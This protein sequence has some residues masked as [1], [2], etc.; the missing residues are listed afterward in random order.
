MRIVHLIE[1]NKKGCLVVVFILPCPVLSC[2][3]LALPCDFFVLPLSDNWLVVVVIAIIMVIG[4]LTCEC[5]SLVVPCT[6]LV[7]CLSC[8]VLR[9]GAN[10]TGVFWSFKSGFLTSFVLLSLIRPFFF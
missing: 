7:L 2:R 6:C 1:E 3:C 8:V 5:D 10:S 9:A 4:V